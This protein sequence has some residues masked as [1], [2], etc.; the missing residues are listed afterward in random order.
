MEDF[1]AS[2]LSR[3]CQYFHCLCARMHEHDYTAPMWQ[4]TKVP[5][6]SKEINREQERERGSECMHILC[7][8]LTGRLK[9]IAS[10]RSSTLI[11]LCQERYL[12]LSMVLHRIR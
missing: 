8:K 4:G 9:V 12:D 7:D 5:R 11:W 3:Y 10:S 6:Y 1:V 2:L